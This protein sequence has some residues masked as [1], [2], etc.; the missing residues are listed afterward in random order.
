[1]CR[2]LSARLLLQG[3]AAEC[4]ATVSMSSPLTAIDW[5]PAPASASDLSSPSTSKHMLAVG[6]ED[7]TVTVLAAPSPEG[8]WQP[9][10]R[11]P[12]LPPSRPHLALSSVP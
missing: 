9:L 7:G 11:S 10:V 4:V 1:M 5:A 8:P 12:A 3:E 6:C 2:H